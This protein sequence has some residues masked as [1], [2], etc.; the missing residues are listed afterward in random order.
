[1]SLPR[2]WFIQVAASRA[3]IFGGRID[4]NQAMTTS[5]GWTGELILVLH[6]EAKGLG[7]PGRSSC[8]FMK[9]SPLGWAEEVDVQ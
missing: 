2:T 9:H 6:D 7:Q 1:M 8:P 5:I 4:Q 3:F